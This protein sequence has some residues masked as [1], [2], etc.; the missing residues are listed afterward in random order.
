MPLIHPSTP[1]CQPLSARRSIRPSLLPTRPCMR[2]RLPRRS[3]SSDAPARGRKA[4]SKADSHSLRC[5]LN[6]AQAGTQ[7][8]ELRRA[9]GRGVRS[10]HAFRMT[11][12]RG[13]YLGRWGECDDKG[14]PFGVAAICTRSHRDALP[15]SLCHKHLPPSRSTHRNLARSPSR[16]RCSKALSTARRLVSSTEGAGGSADA[17]AGLLGRSSAPRGGPCWLLPGGPAWPPLSSSA[18]GQKQE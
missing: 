2:P 16:P 17:S 8:P 3:R 11:T 14:W 18:A 12:K 4:H 15:P 9:C 7:V 13:I 10:N 6:K 1:T 5:H